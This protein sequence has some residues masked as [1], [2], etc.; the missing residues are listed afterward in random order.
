MRWLKSLFRPKT[1]NPPIQE[2]SAKEI[3]DFIL[4]RIAKGERPP[5]SAVVRLRADPTRTKRDK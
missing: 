2:M 5:D 3:E 1:P 4:D